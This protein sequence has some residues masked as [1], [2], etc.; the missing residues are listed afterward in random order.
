MAASF[1]LVAMAPPAQISSTA[2]FSS[3]FSYCSCKWAAQIVQIGELVTLPVVVVIGFLAQ[4]RLLFAMAEDGL[5]PKV[6]CRIDE[7]GRLFHGTLI[8]GIMMVLVAVFVP[9]A[10]VNEVISAGILLAFNLTNASVIML[11][12]RPASPVLAP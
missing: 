9:F 4:P 12:Y 2:G 11:R 6:F 1:S 10:T 3:A 7:S 8:S 5:L